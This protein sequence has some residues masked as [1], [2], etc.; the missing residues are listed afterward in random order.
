MNKRCLCMGITVME[1]HCYANVSRTLRGF[2]SQGIMHV[3]LKQALYKGLTYIYF[4]E[5]GKIYLCMP[6]HTYVDMWIELISK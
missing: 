2:H 1:W 6:K 4:L 5:E 3:S